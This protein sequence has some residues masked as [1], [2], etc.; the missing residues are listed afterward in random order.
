MTLAGN[1]IWFN[2]N[3]E[4]GITTCFCEHEALGI[5][6]TKAHLSKQDKWSKRI[7]RKVSFT[8]MVEIIAPTKEDKRIIWQDYLT[9]IKI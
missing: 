3:K 5:L 9:K 6:S 8:R 1:K 7:G 4:L 2:Y